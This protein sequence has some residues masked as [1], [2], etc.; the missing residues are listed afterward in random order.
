MQPLHT[1]RQ[2]GYVVS[3]L[4]EALKYWVDVVGAGPFFIIE[5]CALRDQI[6]RGQPAAVD[7]DIALGNSGDV[8]IELICQHNDVASIYNETSPAGHVGLHHFGIMPAN[9]ELAKANFRERGCEEAF[10]CTVSRAE[11]AY[12]DTRKHVGHF[13]ELWENSN[14]FNDVGFLVEDAAKNW[15]GSNPVRPMPG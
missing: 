7:V 13:T 15:D 4:D 8:Q 5:H 3:D 6:Y 10:S 2:L 14:V 9:F 12:F 11:L 1:I